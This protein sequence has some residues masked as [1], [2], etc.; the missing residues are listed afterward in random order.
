[1]EIFKINLN[2]RKLILFLAIF[3]VLSLFIISSV[4]SYYIVRNQLI[5]NSLALNSEHANKIAIITDNHFKNILIELG[6]SAKIL[7]KKFDDN[8]IR[9]TEVQR[10]KMQSD[11]YNSVVVSDSEGRLINYSP[12]IL[13]IDK[14]KVQTT[15]GISNSIKEKKPYI[16]SPYLSVK[17]NMIVFISYPIFDEKKRYRGFVG[18]A[19]YLKEKNVINQLLSTNET[20]RKSYMYVIDK[21]DKIIFH[22]DHERIGEIIKNNTGLDYIKK[23]NSGKIR[24]I[25]SRG[26]DN[27]AGFSH[28]K[29]TNWIIVSQQPTKQLLKQ[30][31]SIIYKVSAGIFIF[32]LLIFYVVWK[33]SFFIA[34]PLHKLANMASSL[35]QPEASREIKNI[36]PW[37]YEIVKFKRALLLSVHHFSKKMTEMD[38]FIN[39]DPLTGLMNRRGMHLSIDQK[40]ALKIPFSILLI[41][42]DFFKRVN[43]KY[44]HAEG[45]LVLKN[46]A[47]MMQKNFRKDDVCCRYGGEEFI[48]IVPDVSQQDVYESAERF[49]RE[50]EAQSIEKVGSIT[51]S[52]GIASWPEASEDISEVFILA[53]KNLYE[54]KNS[55]RNCV[56]L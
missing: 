52:I 1:M 47:E 15:L 12:N 10:L 22:P 6:Y 45:D 7:G 33:C 30:A 24:L 39:T 38:Y 53:D 51:V 44:G 32:Y 34:S 20:Y 4:I 31:N 9:E 25:N 18:S 5:N 41:D 42:I 13:N 19:I 55:G 35:H 50:V 16:S 21:N 27:L 26:V 3:S 43:D 56:R 23:Q 49:R 2:L 28:V 17:K 40:I 54:A 14:N 8:E 37:Y 48:V 29:T 11:Y 46:I 36:N